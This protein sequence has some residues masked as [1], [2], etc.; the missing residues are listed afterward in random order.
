MQKVFNVIL[1][2]LAPSGTFK[3]FF[4]QNQIFDLRWLVTKSHFLKCL[5]HKD[6]LLKSNFKLVYNLVPPFLH[7][8]LYMI[9]FMSL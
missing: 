8:L 6:G 1:S 9:D 7:I 4:W 3:D 2:S 5:A